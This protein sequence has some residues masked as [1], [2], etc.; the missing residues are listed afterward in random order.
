MWCNAGCYLVGTIIEG[1]AARKD[2]ADHSDDIIHLE[3]PAQMW[4]AHAA[5]SDVLHFNG[6]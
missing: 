5:A 6:L 2:F 4:I 1:Y 3:R